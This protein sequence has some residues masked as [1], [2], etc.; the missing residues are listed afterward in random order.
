MK[1]VNTSTYT[2]EKL[3]NG[4]CI[5]VDK[6]EYFYKLVTG[7]GGMYFMSRPRRF[8]KSLAVS[9]FDAIF[10]GKKDLFRDL[11]IYDMDYD[12]EVYPVI[13][14]DFA[15]EVLLTKEQFDQSL[16]ESLKWIAKEYGITEDNGS[17]AVFFKKLIRS[18]KKK[19]GKNVVLLIDEYDKPL[20][21]HLS[22]PEEAEEWQKYMDSFYQ[23]IKGSEADLRFVFMTGVTKFAKVSVF[24]KLNNLDDLTMNR[25]YSE[26]FGYTQEELVQY[27][28]GYLDDAVSKAVCDEE[29]NVLDKDALLAEIKRW[30]DGFKFSEYG[31][32]V[33]NPVSIGQFMNGHY[34][35]SN[36]WFATGTP[37]FLMDILKRNGITDMELSGISMDKDMFNTF[38]AVELAGEG[39]PKERIYQMLYQ[40]G[41]LTIDKGIRMP[42]GGALMLRFPNLEVK[43]SFEKNLFLKYTGRDSGGFGAALGFRAVKGDTEGMIELL[44]SYFASFPY[45]IQIKH[46][47][48][49]QSMVRIMFEMSGMKFLTEDMTNTGRIDGV[50]E[51]G[52]HLYIIEFKLNRTSDEALAQIDEKKY[53]EKYILPAKEKGLKLHKLGINFCYDKDVR[54][55]TEWKEE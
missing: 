17:P 39:V 53:A 24:S 31:S 52:E 4:N 48:Y 1:A 6:T 38:D 29:G 12:W 2:F 19:T 20:L 47:K 7:K 5:Y 36:Y 55:I 9:I 27:F 22:S 32:N 28:N 33:Y 30:Y 3:I 8:G 11:K 41:Y 34:E 50:L 15:S 45:D 25:D 54:N 49:Y 43:R 46:E 23:I 26:M 16:K 44:K 35:F 40:T 18:L 10:R 14:L 13:R 51:A 42:G 21:D 37:T